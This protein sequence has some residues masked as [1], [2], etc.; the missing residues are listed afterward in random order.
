MI[1]APQRR[2]SQP[3][4]H[5]TAHR[6]LLAL[7]LA[8]V[9]AGVTGCRG[10]REDRP[11]R[12]FFPDMDDQPKFSPQAGSDFFADGRTMRPSVAG[13]VPFGRTDVT[14]TDDWAAPFAAERGSLLR[15]D[16][17]V[18]RGLEA[19]GTTYVARIPVEVSMELLKRGEERYNIYCVVCHG[20]VGDGKGTV[21][22]SFNPVVP[23]FH[24]P[25]YSDPS[26]VFGRDGYLFHIVRHGKL[27]GDGK[28]TM[29]AYGHAVSEH[30]AW[31]IVSYIRALQA[32]RS[33]TLGDVP[34]AQRQALEKA[35]PPKMSPPAGGAK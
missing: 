13:T 23:T 3:M 14:A 5:S 9:A 30:D 7:A 4:T 15:E 17:L 19:D 22:I 31:A 29:P 24:D 11:P 20:Y 2:T 33:A 10:D 21:G 12:Q 18:Y 6:T 25:K 28:L 16:D 8:G 26:D 1:G 32:S 35:R 34:E 27:G